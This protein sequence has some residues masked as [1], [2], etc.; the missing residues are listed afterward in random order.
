[1]RGLCW[2][3]GERSRCL[4]SGGLKW[5][6][7]LLWTGTCQGTVSVSG[8]GLRKSLGSLSA[9]GC[10]CVPTLLFDLKRPSTEAYRLL[11]GARSWCQRPQ[12]RYF[13][14]ADEHSP[15]CPP[16]TF[17]TPER[18]KASPCLL[19]KPSQTSR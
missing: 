10:G 7:V 14:H 6:M 1:M 13:T 3:P 18:A 12:T 19:G 5:V 15:V 2:L 16:P 9:D 4:P 17:M 11:L 8:C